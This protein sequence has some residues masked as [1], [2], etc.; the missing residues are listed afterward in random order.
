ML[1]QLQRHKAGKPAA[2]K[3][4]APEEQILP[5]VGSYSRISDSYEGAVVGVTD[6]GVKRQ[7]KKNASRAD[8][9]DWRIATPLYVDNNLSAFKKEVTRD[10]FEAMLED[11]E[12]GVIDG[13]VVYNLDRLTRQV[14]ELERV[15]DIYDKGRK[16]GRQMYFA[17]TEG[18]IDLATDDG[19]TLARVMVVFAN[20]ASRDTARRVAAKHQEIR[21]EGRN[22]GGGRPFG[23]DW[24]EGEDGRRVHV[25]NELE[26]DAIRKA[27]VG[28]TDGS[29][30]WRGVVREW[31][32]RGF[33]TPRGRHWTPQAVKGVM[34]SPRLAGWLVHKGGIAVHSQTGELIRA[35]APAL[36]SDEEYEALLVATEAKTGYSPASGRSKY[37]L[38]GIV[39]CAECGARLVGN[40]RSE[41]HFYYACR[42]GGGVNRNGGA[43]C[44]KVTA[45]GVEVDRMIEELILPVIIDHTSDTE[46]NAEK[47]HQ[48]EL[49]GLQNERDS[50]LREYR[51]G[52]APSDAAFPRMKE[53][54]VQMEG[55][56][57]LQAEWLREQRVLEH[58]VGVTRETWPNLS[59]E[60]KRNHVSRYIEAV[61]VSRATRRGN[62]FDRSR[63]SDPVWRT[64]V[65]RAERRVAGTR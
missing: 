32:E 37:L 12:A 8:G 63:V 19:I 61:Y 16:A 49:A 20:K 46:L 56:R 62:T 41:E 31:T 34:R 9:L 39:R 21:D 35:K 10:A 28:L 14:S 38:S 42:V 17:T 54:D 57:R 55:L 33:T 23:W 65:G 53:I 43:A 2:S 13:I 15:I 1:E 26:A 52:R 45:S 5:L 22:V 64:S 7:Q 4:N 24:A 40:R 18:I 36:L 29:M 58:G 60:E 27:A 47:P 50:L 11:L 30:T 6:L 3:S 44:G 25:V 59:V 51:E 48:R